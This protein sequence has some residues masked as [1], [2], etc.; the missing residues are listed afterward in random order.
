MTISPAL[1]DKLSGSEDEIT[2]KL[3]AAASASMD[4]KKID[5]DEKEFR[6]MMNEDAMATEKLAEGIRNF[7]KDIVKKQ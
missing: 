1:L 3:D 2:K 4:I 7:A 5:V 6:W